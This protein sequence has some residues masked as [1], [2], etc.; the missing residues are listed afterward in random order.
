MSNPNLPVSKIIIASFA[1]VLAHWQDFL[2]ISIIPVI[3]ATPFLMLLPELMVSLEQMMGAEKMP[4]A[5]QLPDNTMGYL[6][7]FFYAY[8]LLSIN[9]HRLV[10]LGKQVS[11][12]YLLPEI[13]LKRI[14]RFMGLTLIIMLITTLPMLLTGLGFVQL[15][16]Y[17]LILP[18]LLNFLNIS[19]DKPTSYA[20]N[21]PILVRMNLFFLQ[22]IFP[23][24]VSLLISTLFKMLG[25]GL[26]F[27]WVVQ[28]IMFYWSAI[29]LALCYQIIYQKPASQN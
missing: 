16:M 27:E 18:M 6:V 10:I 1:F 5:V 12:H 14:G 9:I 19:L 13:K 8:V 3:I 25:M 4:L 20:W 11:K 29:S 23:L 7:L 28:F 24:I 22:I 21:M 2:K 17:F 15:L 26:I